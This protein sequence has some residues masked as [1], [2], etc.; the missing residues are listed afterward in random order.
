ME[1]K[2][3][4]RLAGDM[5]VSTL[6]AILNGQVRDPGL[7]IAAKIAA[8]LGVTLD[9][10]MGDEMPSPALSPYDVNPEYRACVDSLEEL[11]DADRR[12]V[13]EF[14]RW[15]SDA[16]SRKSAGEVSG[17]TTT[18]PHHGP[19]TAEPRVSEKT[20]SAVPPI[21]IRHRQQQ[22]RRERGSPAP[23][24]DRPKP[25]QHSTGRRKPP[26]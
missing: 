21:Q 2:R 20:D 8:A 5:P 12:R 6:N 14:V 26:R 25:G 1:Q 13:I 4:A 18:K 16:V 10:L 22:L 24:H 9:E 23:T 11:D 17:V 19:Y 3:L 7:S 15:I